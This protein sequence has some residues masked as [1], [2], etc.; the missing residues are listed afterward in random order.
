M[1]KR[2]FFIIATR[3]HVRRAIF[4]HALRRRRMS[5]IFTQHPRR[6]SEIVTTPGVLNVSASNLFHGR[7]YFCLSK[8]IIDGL[9]TSRRFDLEVGGAAEVMVSAEF[10][11]CKIADT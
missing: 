1:D 11:G 4:L 2:S 6:D 7:K 10:Q 8:I 9:M 3:N 5:K